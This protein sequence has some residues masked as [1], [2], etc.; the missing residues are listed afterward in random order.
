MSDAVFDSDAELSRCRAL[1]DAGRYAEALAIARECV[2]ETHA[3]FARHWKSL[4][5]V[6][7]IACA[8]E[9]FEVA[10]QA[11]QQALDMAQ[12]RDDCARIAMSWNNL[13]V[14]F[15]AASAWDLA[16]E[17]FS[18]I[19][20]NRR[21]VKAWSPYLAHGNL[22]LCHLHLDYL[23]QGLES[24]RQAIRLESADLIAKNPHSF[25]AF[26]LTL[27]SSHCA[28]IASG[29]QKFADVRQKP[30][31]SPHRKKTCIRLC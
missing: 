2:R 1:H 7:N 6:G 13:G 30:V 21:L 29:R 15:V 22:A 17:C 16:I 31:S 24:A 3:D 26:R 18:R 9:Q 28:A 5:A 14:I 23:R 25:V 11:H 8:D 27:Y 4:T 10:L 12:E 19:T 20:E